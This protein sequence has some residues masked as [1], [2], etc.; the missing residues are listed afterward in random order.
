[1]AVRLKDITVD[2][3]AVT[4]RKPI[5]STSVKAPEPS[6]PLE[7]GPSSYQWAISLAGQSMK[8]ESMNTV[9]EA[10]NTWVVTERLKT[11]QGEASDVSVL[12]KATLAPRSREIKQGPLA[13][14]IAFDAGKATGTMAMGGP[15]K[16]LSVDVGGALFADGPAAFR[17]IAALPLKEG[18]STTF[19]NFD[20][21]NQKAA[22]KQAKVSG[23]ED[24]TVPAGTFKAWKVEIKSADGEPG[25]QTVWIDTASRR[26]IRISATL[27]Q[28]GGAI[29]TSEL[30]K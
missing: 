7:V 25:E 13:I 22:L 27:P 6:K 12:D 18:Y 26:I 15:E 14:K 17:S 30:T 21:Q 3:K 5:D 8:M 2:P 10:G 4:L 11:P 23:V 24:V 29:A 16:P 19:R 9:T 20:V 28:M 1:V